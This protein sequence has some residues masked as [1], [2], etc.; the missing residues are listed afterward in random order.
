MTAQIK[1]IRFLQL[2]ASEAL[3]VLVTS[4][5][6]GSNSRDSRA[7]SENSREKKEH[8]KVGKCRNS[9]KS[10]AHLN[11]CLCTKKKRISFHAAVLQNNLYSDILS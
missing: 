2:R 9:R 3:Q 4:N 6:F 7:F 5:I 1:L 10:R 8:K 11:A